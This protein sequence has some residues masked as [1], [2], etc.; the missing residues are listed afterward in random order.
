M[1]E[2]NNVNCAAYRDWH[3]FWEEVDNE[4]QRIFLHIV[5]LDPICSFKYLDDIFKCH[6]HFQILFTEC[7]FK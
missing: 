7:L 6:I 4:I 5:C 1:N 3:Y 2:G